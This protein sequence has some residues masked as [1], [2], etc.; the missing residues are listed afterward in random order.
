[1]KHPKKIKILCP[2]CNKH[3]MHTV[4][5]SSKKVRDSAHTMSQSAKRK[6][7]HKRGYGGHG[8]Y[9]K[10]SVSKKPSQRLDL[11]F[12]CEECGKAHTKK[13]FRIR[14]FELS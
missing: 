13:G 6:I 1:M 5:Q 8:K 11:R 2:K 10:P 9:S 4:K 12:T 7:R 14:K 3:T